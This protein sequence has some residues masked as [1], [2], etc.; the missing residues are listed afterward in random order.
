MSDPSERYSTFEDIADDLSRPNARSKDR[1]LNLLLSD[2]WH[3]KFDPRN[4]GLD[5]Y[6]LS[7]ALPS[8]EPYN[9]DEPASWPSSEEGAIPRPS[10]FQPMSREIAF[11]LLLSVKEPLAYDL[12]DDDYHPKFE[13]LARTKLA[14][15]GAGG[16]AILRNIAITDDEEC[17]FCDRHSL[18]RPKSDEQAPSQEKP[19]A[20]PEAQTD[21]GSEPLSE[22]ELDLKDRAQA[23]LEKGQE[24]RGQNPTLSTRAIASIMVRKADGGKLEG[25]GEDTLRKILGGR[26]KSVSRLGLKGLDQG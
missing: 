14:C 3:D 2:L 23:V 9:P 17:R 12:S 7:L 15:Y 18:K 1:I 4:L 6:R 21:Q 5:E 13:W 25:W 19:Q 11:G 26:Y 20:T 10:D 8:D 24:M 22:I 16:Q